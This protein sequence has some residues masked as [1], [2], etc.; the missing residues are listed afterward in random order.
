MQKSILNR[1]KFIIDID[2][3]NPK[4]GFYNIDNRKIYI[5]L[6]FIQIYYYKKWK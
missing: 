4:I 6:G 5:F 3:V 2:T 1:S